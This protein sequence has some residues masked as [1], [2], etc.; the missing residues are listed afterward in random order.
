M[1]YRLIEGVAKNWQKNVTNSGNY[2]NMKSVAVVT[3]LKLQ[4]TFLL[5]EKF[6]SRQHKSVA[7]ATN[8]HNSR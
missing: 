6:S 8:P 1:S 4:I 2:T 5:A 3:R 7:T